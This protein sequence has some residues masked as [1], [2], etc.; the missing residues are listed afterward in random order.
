M[1]Y[2]TKVEVHPLVVVLL[3][4]LALVGLDLAWT[5]KRRTKRTASQPH[6]RPT[7][8]SSRM[9]P[10]FASAPTREPI[11][12]E[13]GT[14]TVERDEKPQGPFGRR[15]ERPASTARKSAAER[16]KEMDAE[17]KQAAMN[18]ANAY[19]RQQQPT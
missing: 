16:I 17:V 14:V 2:S 10:P 13:P 9:P 8:T 7:A 1:K 12:P 11:T 3:I 4:L 19:V 18:G 15:P 5:D 6:V